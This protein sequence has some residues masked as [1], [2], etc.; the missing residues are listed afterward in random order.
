MGYFDQPLEARMELGIT[1]GFI[2]FAVGIE[3]P[4]DIIADVE[5]A[6]THV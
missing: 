2:R 6:L 3:D 1:N 5:Q 4:R